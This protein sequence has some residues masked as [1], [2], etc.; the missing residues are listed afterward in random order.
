MRCASAGGCIGSS[1]TRRVNVITRLA[2][3]YIYE[4]IFKCWANCVHMRHPFGVFAESTCTIRSG[5]RWVDVYV[6]VCERIGT[7]SHRHIQKDSACAYPR[8]LA[9]NVYVYH[10]GIQFES[11]ADNFVW[12]CAALGNRKVAVPKLTWAQYVIVCARAR[13]CW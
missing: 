5:G 8:S 10:N 3:L 4:L 1:H 12:S 9:A 13:V 6:S 7:H 11:H 2:S